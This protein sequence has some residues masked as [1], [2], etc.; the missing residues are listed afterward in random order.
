MAAQ[1][2][3]ADATLGDL[4]WFEEDR[5]GPVFW[6]S[7]NRF[8]GDCA[9]TRCPIAA[10]LASHPRLTAALTVKQGTCAYVEEYRAAAS[11]VGTRRHSR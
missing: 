7:P 5:D 10:H 2:L 8:C 11:V 9:D 3:V 4:Q 1:L 6:A